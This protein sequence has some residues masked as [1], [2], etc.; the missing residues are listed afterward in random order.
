MHGYQ[1]IEKELYMMLNLGTPGSLLRSKFTHVVKW[2]IK[3]IR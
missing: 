2:I 1:Q 3:E